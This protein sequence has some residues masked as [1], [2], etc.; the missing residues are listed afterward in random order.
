MMSAQPIPSRR[1]A[2]SVVAGKFGDKQPASLFIKFPAGADSGWHTHDEDYS[3]I[4]IEGTFTAQQQGDAAEVQLPIGSYFTQPAKAVHRNG[5]L[6][7]A[8]CLVYV[9]FDKGAQ[10]TPT[11]RE[12]KPVAAK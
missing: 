5:C 2:T 12:G 3:A 10:T 8:D 7:G 6:K 9:H 1:C 4:V 11:T